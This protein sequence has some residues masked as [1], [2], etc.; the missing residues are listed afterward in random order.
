MDYFTQGEWIRDTKLCHTFQVIDRKGKRL[1]DGSIGNVTYLDNMGVSHAHSDCHPLLSDDDSLSSLLMA[2]AVAAAS[3]GCM[4]TLAELSDIKAL[5]RL[6]PEL[7]KAT[8]ASLPTEVKAKI[9]EMSKS[10]LETVA[11]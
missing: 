5:M 11:C 7:L 6:R 8:W 4:D 1:P 10:K 2:T 3:K 9:T